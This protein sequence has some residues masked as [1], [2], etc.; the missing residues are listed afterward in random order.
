MKCPKCNSENVQIQAKEVKP[1]FIV[2]ICLITGGL[3]LMI[4][5]ILGAIIG[6][7]VGVLIGLILLAVLPAGHKAIM[8]CQNC[9]YVS[10]PI[11]QVPLTTQQRP[12]FCAP[13]ESNFEV[14]RNDIDKGTIVVIRIK[15]DDNAPFDIGDNSTAILKLTEGEHIVSYEQINGIGRKKNKGQMN[16]IIGEKKTITIS[17]SRHGLI[18][19]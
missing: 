16:V 4:F 7:V 5:G 19:K 8:I 2:P 11:S 18:V 1:N 13:D 14:V 10:Q 12:L 3:G 15:I 17:F 9:G 6:L